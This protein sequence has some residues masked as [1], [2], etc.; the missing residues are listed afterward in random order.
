L[1]RRGLVILGGAAM[2]AGPARGQQK[3]MPA[4]GYLHFA[5]PDYLPNAS[6]FLQGLGQAGYVVGKN[7]AIE[8]RYANG[9]YD[10]LPALA[11]ELIARNVDLIAAFG[12]PT[13]R[14]AKN[15]TSTIP[16]VFEVGNDPVAAGLV[17]SLARPGDN[18]TGVSILFTQ[19]TAKRIELLAELVPQAKVIA[20][21]VNPNSPTAEPTIRE[22][23]VA[24]HATALQIPVLKATTESEIDAVFATLAALHVD[25]LVVGAD[26]FFDVRR[27]QLV[28]AAAR[29]AV[30]TTYFAREFVDAGGLISYGTSLSGVYR[31]VGQ[32]A[33][34]ILKGEKPA[35]LPVQQPT[36]FELVINLKTAKSLGLAVAQ[37]LLAQ[38]DEVIE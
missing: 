38:A 31:L 36:T 15:A 23:Q 4:V 12:P 8:Y 29:Q 20:V 32:Y 26:P 17:A 35:D 3:A 18:A 9:H 5:A 27:T 19:L 2:L 21:L 25:G 13:A 34:R 16:I 33:A 22:A 37:S 24:G 10:Q 14:A 30:P 1:N 28:S 11:A 6:V 7:V